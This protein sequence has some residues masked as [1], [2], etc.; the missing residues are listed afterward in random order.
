MKAGERLARDANL[1]AAIRD[2]ESDTVAT[3]RKLDRRTFLKLTGL[4]GG[5]LTL[6]ACFGGDTPSA[7]TGQAA[8]FEPNAF[9]RIA[10]DG[11]ILIYSKIPEIGQ[12]IKTSLP[13]IIAEEL[14]A[15]WER[16]KIEQAVINP[17]VYGRQSA[18]GSR[19]VATS[20][21]QLR[22][23]G[24]VARSMLVSAAAEKWQVPENECVTAA[25]VVTHRPSGKQLGYGELAEAAA[26][27]PVPPVE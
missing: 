26:G 21:D 1:R 17:E 8:Q 2:A 25:S 3:W 13:M 11:T 10:T 7:A 16:V 23:A 19:S 22:E 14:D 9:V 15:D 4:A 27:L 20:W 12:G 6:A 18:G 5:G 24:A